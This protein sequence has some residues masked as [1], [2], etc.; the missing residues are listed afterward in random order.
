MFNRFQKSENFCSFLADSSDTGLGVCGWILVI[1][2]LFFTV[3]TFPISIWMCI[4]VELFTAKLDENLKQC[5]CF[6]VVITASI[7]FT[8][9]KNKLV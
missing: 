5:R 7:L 2:S 4:K 8:C 3:L 1:T 6:L 9:F